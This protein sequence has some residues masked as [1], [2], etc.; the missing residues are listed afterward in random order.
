MNILQDISKRLLAVASMPPESR[1]DAL[2]E[3]KIAIEGVQYDMILEQKDLIMNIIDELIAENDADQI[4]KSKL[5]FVPDVEEQIAPTKKTRAKKV[6][7]PVV[8]STLED[9]P[10]DIKAEE[11][12]DNL[13]DQVLK[14]AVLRNKQEGKNPIDLY[15]TLINPFKWDG[16]PEGEYFWA[17]IHFS[18]DLTE[19]KR[20]YGNKGEKVD[21]VIELAELNEF[22]EGLSQPVT[23]G[24][25]PDT[26]G[27]EI[28]VKDLPEQVKKLVLFRNSESSFNPR[29]NVVNDSIQFA[30]EWDKTPEGEDF[31]E[32]ITFFGDLTEFKAK[33]GNKG[34]KVDA[35][36]NPAPAVKTRKPRTPKVAP[37]VEQKINQVVVLFNSPQG[38]NI[39]LDNFSFDE[40]F[41]SMSA[42]LYKL[43]YRELSVN[44][45]VITDNNNYKD[46]VILKDT[47]IRFDFLITLINQFSKLKPILNW[48]SFYTKPIDETVRKLN[49]I[50]IENAFKPAPVVAPK[51][52]KVVAPKPTKVVTPKPVKVVAPKVVKTKVTKP[53]VEDDLSFLND[54]DNIF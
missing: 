38:V 6:I 5:V 48:N 47:D 49:E 45:E 7:A 29:F 31:W 28:P 4:A 42:I 51:P 35:I 23:S 54:L 50:D 21:E 34:E 37:V 18:G 22:V 27:K 52:V 26:I 15:E 33:F 2:M 44:I 14:L 19:F 13:P 25:L 32:N 46:N 40:L 39:K 8:E 12:L 30:F 43:K 36:I 9:L 17:K 20:I 10:D 24:D 11:L 16:T 41:A 1:N 3:V 53:K